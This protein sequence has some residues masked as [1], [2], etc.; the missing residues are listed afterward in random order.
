GI[1]N[2]LFGQQRER[3]AEDGLLRVITQLQTS[4]AQATGLNEGP[5]TNPVARTQALRAVQ[6]GLN[7][8]IE[9]H[10]EQL[11]GAQSIGGWSGPVPELARDVLAAVQTLR[12][13]FEGAEHRSGALDCRDVI[14]SVAQLR[15]RESDSYFNEALDGLVAM[16]E[17]VYVRIGI[18]APTA[19]VAVSLGDLWDILLDEL[20]ALRCEDPVNVEPV[21]EVLEAPIGLSELREE[22][23]V[24]VD[25]EEQPML[26]CAQDEDGSNVIELARFRRLVLVAC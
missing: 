26:R 19:G 12:P 21:L 15:G 6:D 24:D 25:A 4:L 2:Q 20:R 22:S 5:L 23:V 1:R 18:D 10:K 9:W 17:A 8:L 16:L 14:Q 7:G 11:R 3:D 13:L